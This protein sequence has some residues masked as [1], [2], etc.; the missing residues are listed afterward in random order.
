MNNYKPYFGF[1]KTPFQRNIA[2]KNLLQTDQMLEVASRIKYAVELGGMAIVTGEVGTGKSTALRYAIK[3]FHPSEYVILYIVATTGSAIEIYKQICVELKLDLTSQ[4]KSFLIK[5][6]KSTILEFWARKQKPI[7]II[8]E[9]SLLRI[10]I[11]SEL[12][13]ITQFDLDSTANL[14]IILAGQNSLI[15]ALQYQSSRAFASRIVARSKLEA[16]KLSETEGYL[17]HHLKLVGN[18]HNLF[19]EAAITAIHKLSFGMLRKINNIARG[20]LIAAAMKQSQL[21][22]AEHV[23][24][25][26]SETF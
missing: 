15:D 9:A 21:V 26:A 18:D 11:F 14:P 2:V 12:H 19:T 20:S 25:A 3:E 13:T 5:Q 10:D 22:E 23:Q 17:L 24:I 16:L 8:D 7:L 6:I 4:S 1:T